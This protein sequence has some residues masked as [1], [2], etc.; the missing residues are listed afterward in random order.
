MC[1]RNQTKESGFAMFQTP[2]FRGFRSV[3]RRW[4]LI[5][6]LLSSGANPRA[7]GDS[8]PAPHR[9]RAEAATAKGVGEIREIVASARLSDLRW[10]DFSD[11]RGHLENFYQSSGY[12]SAWV[13][14]NQPTAQA[15][16][17]IEVLR[18]A[19]GKGLNSED[20]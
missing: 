3:P 20:Y 14:E 6:L 9:S 2:F 10:P 12:R 7:A 13:R 1:V 16:A 17:I 4:L 15:R 18:Q 5:A 11:Y 8:A 19:D